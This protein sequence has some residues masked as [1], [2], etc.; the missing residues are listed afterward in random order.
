MTSSDLRVQ[1]TSARSLDW[2]AI[3]ADREV[4][5]ISAWIRPDAR[6]SFGVRGDEPSVRAALVQALASK[7]S[8]ELLINVCDD[9]GEALRRY[10]ELGFGMK[11]RETVYVILVARAELALASTMAPTG[12]RLRSI[13]D[14]NEDRVRVLDDVLRHDT[15]GTD[16]W[17]WSAEDFHDETYGPYLDP[18][19]YLIA[20]DESS[21]S[22]VGIVRV[23]VHEG[24]PPRLGFVGVTRQERRRG[25]ARSLLAAAFRVLA[26]HHVEAVT[27]EIDVANDASNALMASLGATRFGGYVEL[28]LEPRA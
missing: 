14:V 5:S 21:G 24:R 22:D 10:Q 4:G 2:R 3:V 6:C 25:I 16:G 18:A 23:W 20:E 26:D 19:L 17:R 15:P 27:T 9:D 13:A 11:R 1:R 12:V 7:V 8:C 28:A